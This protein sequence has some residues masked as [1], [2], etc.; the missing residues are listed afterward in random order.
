MR[1]VTALYISA[2]SVSFAGNA[3]IISP[4]EYVASWSATAVSHMK[5]YKIPASITLAQG[6]V[7]SGNGNSPLA[8][9]ANNHFG[10][11]CHEWTGEKIYLDDDQKGECF[12]KY[13]SGDESYRDHSLFLVNRS[14]YA[15][16]FTLDPTDYKAWAKGLKEAGYA[17]SPVYPQ[18]LIE[19]I[20]RLGL[21]KYDEGLE[22]PGTEALAKE[23]ENETKQ[24]KQDNVRVKPVKVD[25]YQSHQVK[26]NDNR[27]RYIVAKQGDT[28]AK[29]AREMDMAQRQLYRYNDFGPKKDILDEG[30]IVW[31]QPKRRHAAE[32]DAILIV[33]E[34]TTLRKI[35][36][37]TGVKLESLMEFNQSP[38]ADETVRK[39]Q[40][41]RLR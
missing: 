26:T 7:E 4:D 8:V 9:Q 31:L 22:K 21:H 28:Y 29:I 32:K 10:I 24:E 41:I 33:K 2:I 25:G 14:R 23:L 38:G 3:R 12:R 30:D 39:G 37:E 36:Q 20:E 6:I 40:K 5:S 18:K 1:F 19:V 17:T 13:E 34:S 27:M 16:L 15:K 35:S 11:K